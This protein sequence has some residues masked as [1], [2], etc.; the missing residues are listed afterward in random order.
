MK[1]LGL[2]GG[3]GWVSTAEYYKLINEMVNSRMGELNSARMMIYSFNYNDIDRFNKAGNAE[4]VKKMVLDAASVLFKGG[5]E[6]I[7]LCANTLHQFAPEV[8][9]AVPIPVIH[10]GENTAEKISADG[11]SKAGLL[12]TKQT[13]EMDF[14]KLKLKERGIDTITPDEEDRI[15]IESTI[16]NE[17]LKS[18]FKKESKERFI[19][20]INKLKNEGAGAIILGCT[21]IPL[22]I[23]QNDTG[24]KVYNT[25][26]IHAEA[27]VEFAAGL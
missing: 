22:L 19:E 20:I 16:K 11:F 15:F 12:G 26:L 18:I 23:N 5:A 3:T 25:M 24:I 14:Y 6:G 17:L 13:M 10:I 2:I 21:E 9:K 1:T 4:G 27:A 7:L 8:E